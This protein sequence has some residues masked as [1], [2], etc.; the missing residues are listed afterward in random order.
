MLPD[1]R[2]IK[3]SEPAHRALDGA[4]IKTLE[5]A[6]QC[7]RKQLLALHGF[8]PKGLR[9]LVEALRA[10]GLGLRDEA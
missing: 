3:L 10:H 1:L 4:D 9:L 6:A 8:G 7:T 5:Q 2:T